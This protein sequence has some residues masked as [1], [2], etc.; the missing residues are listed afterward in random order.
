MMVK[1]Q[2]KEKKMTIVHGSLVELG[3]KELPSGSPDSQKQE[4]SKK[5]ELSSHST[6]N[7]FTITEIPKMESIPQFDLVSDYFRDL[8]ANLKLFHE[9]LSHRV[10]EIFV[11]CQPK[12]S[13]SK[14][15][16]ICPLDGQNGCTLRFE[17][18]L[19][20][21]VHPIPEAAKARCCHKC[22][23]GAFFRLNKQ[24]K[25][26]FE[27]LVQDLQRM[28]EFGCSHFGNEKKRKKQLANLLVRPKGKKLK[29]NPEIVKKVQPSLA[30][31][32][33]TATSSAPL[34]SDNSTNNRKVQNTNEE[35]GQM[36]NRTDTS[37]PKFG[38][39]NS[40][41]SFSSNANSTQIKSPLMSL[42]SNF[43]QSPFFPGFSSILDG[44]QQLI[45]LPHLSMSV[46]MT[47][48]QSLPQ[49]QLHS[50]SSQLPLGQQSHFVPQ[51]GSLQTQ[52][53]TSTKSNPQNDV[54]DKFLREFEAEIKSIQELNAKETEYLL[55]K[56][57]VKAAK[58]DFKE[59]QNEITLF[60]NEL[61]AQYSFHLI[62]LK[63]LFDER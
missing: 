43:F 32:S 22:S 38:T 24:K 56:L 34:I 52:N 25:N 12:S 21:Y 49:Q 20:R 45:P 11:R 58:N 17:V 60:F 13:S 36:P 57:R 4:P 31:L 55:R 16:I 9:C 48:M 51:S 35:N 33:T 53:E 42:P 30:L 26:Q 18:T 2:F 3:E 41:S 28:L 29:Y 15:Q 61:Q 50:Q 54:P 62:R 40:Q 44:R 23:H 5:E 47:I 37:V 10:P 1:Q 6:P 7:A 14:K 8:D 27:Q 19:L 63:R 39:N 59:I 46:P